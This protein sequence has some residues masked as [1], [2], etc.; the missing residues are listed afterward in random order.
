MSFFTGKQDEAPEVETQEEIEAKIKLG[1]MEYSQ[2]ELQSLVGLAQKTK[3]A[4]QKYNTSF[5]K[6]WPEY[7]RSQSELKKARERIEELERLSQESQDPELTA[8]V[9][10]AKQ[11]AREIGLILDDDLEARVSGVMQKSFQ[12]FYTEQREAEQLLGELEKLEGD[13]GSQEGDTRP[14]FNKTQVLEHMVNTGFKD[15]MKA[16]EDLYRSETDEWRA[17]KLLEARKPGLVTQEQG[18][19]APK[20]PETPKVHDG[21]LKQMLAEIMNR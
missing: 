16:Y 6:V 13:I 15:P 19:A 7:G 3:E 11:A 2:D 1:E 8:S 9:A 5:E 17:R 12:R 14:K 18:G 10:E 20:M 21:N 4:E